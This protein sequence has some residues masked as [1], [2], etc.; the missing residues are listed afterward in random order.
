MALL[1]APY[2][3]SMK[4]GQGFNS[5]THEL[6]IDGAVEF[7][8]DAINTTESPA[9]VCSTSYFLAVYLTDILRMFRTLH[10]SSKN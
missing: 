8:K 4:L 3:D 10:A 7:G 6:C 1:L 9:Q 2:N 5:Y